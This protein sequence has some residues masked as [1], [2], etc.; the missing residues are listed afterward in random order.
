M[1]R[2]RQTTLG[3][4]PTEQTIS[5]PARQKPPGYERREIVPRSLPEKMEVDTGAAPFYG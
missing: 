4:W 1:R 2:E 3:R 5:S